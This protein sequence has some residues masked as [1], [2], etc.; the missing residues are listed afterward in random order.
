MSQGNPFVVVEALLA[1]GRP[2]HTGRLLS[3]RAR[4]R[5]RRLSHAGSSTSAPSAREL[6]AVGAVIG[7]A[8]TFT[9]LRQARRSQRA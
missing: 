1:V 7:R 2:G 6:A 5:A 9:L 8:F 3:D 4:A